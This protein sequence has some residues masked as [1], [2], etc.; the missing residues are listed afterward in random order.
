MASRLKIGYSTYLNPN[1][2]VADSVWWRFKFPGLIIIQYW[3]IWISVVIERI[4][5]PWWRHKME[6]FSAL[7]AFC[8]VNSLHKSQWRGALM[9]SLTCVWINGWLNNSEAG[10]LRRYRAHYDV[11]VKT[12]V[13]ITESTILVPY[14]WIRSL[15]FIWRSGTR[16]FHLRVLDLRMSVTD[17]TTWQGTRIVTTAMFTGRHVL[18]N[19]P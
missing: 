12:L 6:T 4:V 3:I 1:N 8:T 15:S 18:M 10:D 19:P 16:N 9:L 11:T 2:P 14:L 17:F 7:L 5:S 13:A